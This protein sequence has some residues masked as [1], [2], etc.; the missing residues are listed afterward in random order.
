[1]SFCRSID[2]IT[3]QCILIFSQ[4][5]LCI[6]FQKTIW[7]MLFT[8]IE[9][10]FRNS[11]EMIRLVKCHSAIVR[12]SNQT[13][14]IWR[15]LSN[16]IIHSSC[17]TGNN[18][19][20]IFATLWNA[21]D[22]LSRRINIYVDF[23]IRHILHLIIYNFPDHIVVFIVNNNIYR[24]VGC[25][26]DSAFIIELMVWICIRN[27]R[28]STLFSVVSTIRSIIPVVFWSNFDPAVYYFP[29]TIYSWIW[30]II[31]FFAIDL[32]RSSLH[33]STMILVM[34][35]AITGAEVIFPFSGFIRDLLC[36]D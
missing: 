2:Q 4:L 32:N 33:C 22:L 15:K 1:M 20:F 11:I 5:N 16:R 35:W 31:I 14:T 28:K 19:Q 21:N 7:I 23:I 27:F 13:R 6:F 24:A 25:V 36:S 17:S 18:L 30:I 10:W 8:I 34:F 26:S 29:A 3:C 9:H 12:L